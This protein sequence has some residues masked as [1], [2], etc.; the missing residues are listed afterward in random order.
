MRSSSFNALF[1]WG[2]FSVEWKSMTT[3]MYKVFIDLEHLELEET[4]PATSLFSICTL[5]KSLNLLLV[6]WQL[7]HST[8]HGA[9]V[10]QRI[11]KEEQTGISLVHLTFVPCLLI[12]L[13]PL[14][15]PCVLWFT[16]SVFKAVSLV[17]RNTVTI[18]CTSVSLDCS[19][20]WISFCGV[21]TFHHWPLRYQYVLSVLYVS[22]LWITHTYVIELQKGPG[23]NA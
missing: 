2:S 13:H 15:F 23:F 4:A 17:S 7:S 5:K 1:L 12:D 19:F 3:S 10:R 20:F 18:K 6:M 8:S 11:S 14:L 16:Y 9:G 22:E 21:S